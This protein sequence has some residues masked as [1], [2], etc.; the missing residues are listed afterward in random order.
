MRYL[1]GHVRKLNHVMLSEVVLLVFLIALFFDLAMLSPFTDKHNLKS[2]TTLLIVFINFIFVL[3]LLLILI[4]KVARRRNTIKSGNGLSI[5]NIYSCLRIFISKYPILIIVFIYMVV[6]FF[7]ID[8]MLRW[9]GAWYFCRLLESVE[10]FDFTFGSFLKYFNWYGHPSMGYAFLMSFGQFLDLGNQIIVCMYKDISHIEALLLTTLFAFNPLFFGVSL[11]FSI[12]FPLIVFLP[13]SICALLYNR[14]IIF[15]LSGTILV[16]SKETGALL[17]F[18]MPIYIIFLSLLSKI[19]LN[20]RNINSNYSHNNQGNFY[21]EPCD[22]THKLFNR[23][24]IL[25]LSI[26]AILFILYFIYVGG[27]LWEAGSMGWNNEG[28]HAFGFSRG[29]IV[30]RLHQIFILNF[31]WLQ[32]LII[33]VYI[34]KILLP[35]N[36]HFH[37]FN[38]YNKA[39]LKLLLS[40]FLVFIAFNLFYITFNHPRY[41]L[42]SVFFL[43]IFSHYALMNIFEE[44]KMRI[45]ILSIMIFLSAA[46]T[47]KTVD[48]LSN[49]IFKTFDFGM[50]QMLNI[51]PA[52]GLVYNSE[53]VVIERILNKLNKEIN[54]N[55]NSVII[56]GNIWDA[57][58]NGE[59][60]YS[61]IN[62]DRSSLNRT[63]KK[64]NSF[65]PKVY[66]IWEINKDNLPQEAYYL[67]TWFG[68][69][70]SELGYLQN[71][72]KI[73]ESKKIDY[74]GYYYY[75]YKLRL[76]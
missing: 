55:E 40:M 10:N 38:Q 5:H 4:R 13:A 2:T 43:L 56:V 29:F 57:H 34:T 37:V 76:S 68:D 14:M 67:Y 19:S 28:V 41:V 45:L 25:C 36:N 64:D 51:N 72:Y 61:T 50:H 58:F 22:N 18:I 17:Y 15:I 11:S 54:I 75:L 27:Q 60:T 1:W 21:L 52:D 9:D 8:T 53:Y 7:Y 32:S 39:I 31:G 48:P 66:L 23:N 62:I 49:L 69:K 16:F 73:I 12:D 33:L 46:Q 70:Q 30:T 71:H 63:F 59:G 3:L 26:P 44:E 47:F 24:V 6:R 35:L 74:N 42:V 65:Q 20:N